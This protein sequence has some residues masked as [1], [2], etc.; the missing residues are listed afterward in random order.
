MMDLY[1]LK[2]NEIKND[3]EQYTAFKSNVSTVVKAGPGSGKTTVLTL[4]IIN[5]L[6][7]KINTPRGLACITYSNEAVNEFTTRLKMM[8]YKKRKNVVLNTVHSFCI[9]EIIVPFA[10]LYG[11][12]VS[13]PLNII[14]GAEK[15]KIFNEILGKLA[16]DKKQLNQIDMDKERSVRIGEDSKVPIETYDIAR[17]VAVEYEKRLTAMEKV[18]FVE[19]IKIATEL[20]KEQEYVRRCLEAKF[21]WILIDEYQDLGKPLHE[22]IL[23]LF[24]KTN[25]KLFVVGDPDQSIYGF[26]G[27]NPEYLLELY[28]N[29][30]IL[31][32][33]LSTNYRSNQEVIDF[34]TIALNL[35]DRQYKAGTRH[36][37]KAEL[38]FITCEDEMNDQ[39]DY[40]VNQ[41]IPSCIKQNIPLDE[42]CVLAGKGVELKNLGKV[43]DDANIP[44][45]F[46]KQEYFKS[47]IVLWLKKCASWINDK[48][49][50]AFSDL[51]KFWID[52]SQ[53]MTDEEKILETK[54]FYTVLNQSSK[55]EHNLN[56]WISFILEELLVME[57]ASQINKYNDEITVLENFYQSTEKGELK[58][59]DLD[60]FSR[61][62]KPNN[63]VTL[64]TRH[65]SKGLEYEVVILL[66]LEEGNFP[67]YKNVKD[68]K[69][70]NEDRRLFYV[71]LTRAKRVCFLLRSKR[72][73][74]N[75]KYGPNCKRPSMFWNELLYAQQTKLNHRNLI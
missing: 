5:L 58:S 67:F 33:K 63:Q 44:Y 35:D 25:I 6:R 59:Y 36:G 65:S 37:E 60:R 27:G 69:K 75:P 62:G 68:E 17:K 1:S 21:P 51:V 53:A 4:K 73:T 34:A 47:E 48:S 43:M 13:Y 45:Y 23:T 26:Q 7:E 22:M 39:Y 12:K 50:I 46:A 56:K 40:V 15:R 52:I 3:P 11:K 41:I 9:S 74:Y 66:G 55:Y 8:G 71:C 31:P 16:I 28:R 57:K 29:P 2:L 30:N 14:T 32:I 54:S 19:L 70:L 49:S 24:S 42:I 72:I 61:L 10:E 18:D 64:S 38:H 20:I